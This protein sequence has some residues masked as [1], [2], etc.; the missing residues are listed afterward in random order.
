TVTQLLDIGDKSAFGATITQYFG[1]LLVAPIALAFVIGGAAFTRMLAAR[2][3]I[4]GSSVYGLRL[5]F[6][7]AFVIS[8]AI[9]LP[10]IGWLFC[11][12]AFVLLAS[13]AGFHA[14]FRRGS[15]QPNKASAA[16]SSGETAR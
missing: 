12:P 7:S 3:R 8:L 13:G 16:A 5:L 1:W 14:L 10:I 9:F 6:A 15:A 4:E 11:L 2:M